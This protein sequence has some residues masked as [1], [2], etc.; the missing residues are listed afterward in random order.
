MTKYN[1]ENI[2]IS[3]AGQPI[4]GFLQVDEG[5]C[6]NWKSEQDLPTELQCLSVMEMLSKE[7]LIYD[8]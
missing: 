8:C 3:I 1:H 4:T 7:N 6:L 5:T 2:K